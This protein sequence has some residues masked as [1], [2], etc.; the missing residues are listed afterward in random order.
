[1]AMLAVLGVVFAF[2]ARTPFVTIGSAFVFTNIEILMVLVV[3]AWATSLLRAHRRPAA[4]SMV[5]IP[6]L[7]WIAALLASTASAQPPISLPLH[8]VARMAMGVAVAWI[9]YDTLVAS[10][11]PTVIAC[12]LAVGGGLVAVLGL[13]ESLN[14]P[15]LASWLDN[16]KVAPTRVGDIVRISSTLS[17]ATITSMVLE[18]TFPLTLAWAVVAKNIWVRAL[19]TGLAFIELAVLVLTLSRAGVIALAVALVV[20][21]V[22]AWLSHQRQF[23]YAGAGAVAILG[24]LAGLSIV[25]NPEIGLRLTNESDQT[26]FKDSISVPDRLTARPGSVLQIPVEVTNTSV[27]S[28]DSAPAHPFSLGYH[29][30]DSAHQVVTYDGAR[31]PLGADVPP[32]GV[33][34]VDARL[35]APAR[36]DTYH[37]EWDVVQNGVAWF[38]WKGSATTPTTLTVNG[39]AVDGPTVRF[40]PPPQDVLTLPVPGRFQLWSAGLAMFIAHPL[41]GVGPDNFRWLY[42]AYAQVS[43]WNVDIHANNLYVELLADTGLIGFLAFLWL[44]W[45]IFTGSITGLR[46]APHGSLW[47]WRVAVLASLTAW[48][49]HGV[50]DYFFEFTPTYVAFWMIV[51][52]SLG[53]AQLEANERLNASANADRV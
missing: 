6:T 48:F 22:I 18:L 32:N 36:P 27:K 2:E 26:W 5:I 47:I 34:R 13:A 31:T 39:A 8:F 28:W 15:V 3:V 37:V 25:Y 9:C 52:L 38:S 42:G 4:P 11:R 40:V 16:F 20:V 44:S 45:R 35:I 24:I 43:R 41:L 51:G 19:V 46:S 50:F 1:M 33:V 29:L 7:G 17:Y 21:I 53:F 30:Y 12:G 14:L 23:A 49:V 10:G